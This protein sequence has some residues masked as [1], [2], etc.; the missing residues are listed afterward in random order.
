MNCSD[1]HHVLQQRLDGEFDFDH[2]GVH[3]HLADCHQCRTRFA[4]ARQLEDGLRLLAP[5]VPPAGLAGRITARV[6]TARRATLG[7]RR[8]MMTT[9]ALAASLLLA[10]IFGYPAWHPQK[11]KPHQE[12]PQFANIQPPTPAAPPVSLNRS[13]EEAGSALAALVER[14]TGETMGQGRLLLPAAVSSPSLPGVNL[15]PQP[16]D[17]PVRSLREAGQGLSDGLEPVAV[18]ARRAVNIFFRQL[19]PREPERRQG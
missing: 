8:S 4:A 1:F 11:P 17:P 15:W 13:A 6:L 10:A 16:L 2:D 19:T 3:R 14:T 18:S 12:E 7:W 9:A 5:P